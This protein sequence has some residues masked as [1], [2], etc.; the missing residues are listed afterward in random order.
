LK[1]E[2]VRDEFRQDSHSGA[3]GHLSNIPLARGIGIGVLG[4]LA[5]ALVMDLVIVGELLMSRLPALFYLD[6]IGSIFGG[7]I[8]LGAL[9]HVLLGSFLGIVFILPVLKVD[10]LHID[11]LRKGVV[12]G[13]SA[14]LG[15]ISF[16]VPFA[17]LVDRPIVGLLGFMTIPH[18]VWGTVL[19]LIAG[20]GL[21][22][23]E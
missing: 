6:L 14:G 8:P 15:S 9:V 1:E 19:G 17:I 16:C 11:I 20:Y 10:A 22:S 18:L 5:G 12:L 13:F 2:D 7:G 21:R 4:S 3:G 23:R